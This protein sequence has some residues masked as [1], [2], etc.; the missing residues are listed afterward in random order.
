MAIK[1]LLGPELPFVS[2]LIMGVV[3]LIHAGIVAVIAEFG[4]GEIRTA[5]EK[6]GVD[7]SLG[8]P[9]FVTLD[10]KIVAGGAGDHTLVEGLPE[11]IG[12]PLQK[13][14]WW[15]HTDG[16]DEGLHQL[17]LMTVGTEMIWIRLP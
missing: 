12:H 14:L 17:L 11:V 16:M 13:I 15:F 6:I 10:G 8:K 7:F 9:F 4:A 2:Y 1:A 3:A 5:A